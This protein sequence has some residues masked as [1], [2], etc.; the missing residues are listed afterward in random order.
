MN[1]EL[2]LGLDISTSVVGYCIIDKKGNLHNLS[3]ISLSKLE[4]LFDKAEAV[5]EILK[6]YE[7]LVSHIAIEEP[8]VMFQEGFSRAQILSKL[9]M[10]N[11]MV[12]MMTKFIYN[13]TPV[14]YNVNTAR[15][16]S[17]PDLR[18]PKGSDRKELVRTEIAKKYTDI[19]WPAI[20]RGKNEGKP[21]KECYDMADSA[22]IALAHLEKLNE[23]S[24]TD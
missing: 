9:S 16:L 5:A 20:S 2:I 3:Y 12:S 13:Q 17:F 10:F 21:R 24:T 22:I 19:D 23:Q 6:D 15:K 18:F 4:T 1:N 7:G 8:L 11:G 14:Y